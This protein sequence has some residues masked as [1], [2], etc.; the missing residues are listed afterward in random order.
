MGFDGKGNEG[1]GKMEVRMGDIRV[2]N[3]SI[4]VNSK[5]GGIGVNDTGVVIREIRYG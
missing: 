1:R 3:G 5:I 2:G 4:K